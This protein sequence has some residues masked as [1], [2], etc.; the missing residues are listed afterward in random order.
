ML[1]YDTTCRQSFNNLSKWLDETRNYAN[2]K[3]SVILVGN[4][5]DL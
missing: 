3:L 1:V 2:E 5:I 4:K